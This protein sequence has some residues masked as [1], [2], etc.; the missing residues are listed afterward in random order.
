[1]LLA[2]NPGKLLSLLTLVTL[3]ITFLWTAQGAA[4]LY[5]QTILVS[6]GS[7]PAAHTDANLVD[8]RGI[9]ASATSPFWVANHGTGLATLYNGSGVPSS[10]VV[11]IPPPSGSTS[12][13]TPTGLVFNGGSSFELNPGFPA[14]FLF[15][16]QDGTISGWNPGVAATSA[17]LKVD[18]SSGAGYTGL[19]LGNNGSGDFLYAA[20][21]NEGFVAVFDSTFAPTTVGG[22]FTDPNLPSDYSPFNIQNLGGQLFVTYAP[23]TGTGGI[24]DVFDLNGNLQRRLITGGGLDSPWG[25][26]IAPADFGQYGNA[27]LVGNHG[28]GHINAFDPTTGN[29]LGILRDTHGDI[30]IDG[31]WGLIFGNGGNVNLLYFTAG[32]DG[33]Q[34]GLVGSLAPVPIP[35][36]ALLLGSGLLGLM[37]LGRSRK[38]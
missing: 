18:N 24:V 27:L 28:D 21:F 32:P 29:L 16:T 33:G 6:D 7:V 2:R 13:S 11:S 17:V 25:L 15:A 26:A 9:S 8:P 10:L 31:L 35:G 36:A 20:N 30:V 34:H 23:N 14:R 38:S 22:S 1:M 19:A 37:G 12:L 3:T 5:Q 4:A